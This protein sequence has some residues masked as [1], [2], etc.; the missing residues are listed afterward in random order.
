MVN[1]DLRIETLDPASDAAAR[2]LR[3]AD[4][5]AAALYP[6]ESN[7]LES[8]SELARANVEFV[9]AY[10]G[11]ELV[12][13]GAAKLLEDDGR[14]G[15]IKRLFVVG[16]HRGKGV[17]KAVMRYLEG[18]LQEAGAEVVRLETGVSQPEALAL[19]RRLGYTKREPFGGYSPDPLSVFMEKRLAS[20]PAERHE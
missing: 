19:Y 15:E 18:H 3:R 16:R 11:D 6:P 9:G 10:I 20:K 14:Y 13:C 17:A 4:E 8:P 5:L 12:A 1:F 2:L 7:H